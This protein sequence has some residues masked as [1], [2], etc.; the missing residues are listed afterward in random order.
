MLTHRLSSLSWV[1]VDARSPGGDN[2][3][4][5]VR[6][7]TSFVSLPGGDVLSTVLRELR[8]ESAAYRWLELSDPFLVSFDQPVL[9]GV[10]IVVAGRC[11]L[12]FP[13]GTAVPLAAGDLV[14]V[15]R[16]DRHVLRTGG[17]AGRTPAVSSFE[18]A[19]RQPDRIRLRAGGDGPLSTVVCGAFVVGEPDHPALRGLPRVIHLSG[20]TGWLAPFVDLL[21]AEAFEGGPGG[22]IVMARLSDALVARALRDYSASVTH[23]GW[24][25]GLGDGYVAAALAAIHR[26]PSEPWTLTGLARVAGLSRAAFAARFAARVGEPAMRYLLSVRLQRARTLLR[27]HDLTVAAIAAQVGYRS[28]VAFAAAFKR[29]FGVA[30]GA[31]RRAALSPGAVAQTSTDS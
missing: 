5:E 31:Y 17:R 9:R 10:H 2:P 11:Q 15:P 8:F 28:D 14:I 22:D 23:P 27:N 6:E 26:D 24:L 1:S 18:L 16:G 12:A 7:S 3:C 30:P 25:A 21:R 19:A 20:G 4:V 29:E 13:D